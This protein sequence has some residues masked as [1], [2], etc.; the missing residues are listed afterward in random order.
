MVNINTVNSDLQAGIL[1]LQL[2]EQI[3]AGGETLWGKLK[4]VLADHGIAA[5]N[6]E[7]DFIILDAAKRK[8]QAELDAAGGSAAALGGPVL[9]S[10]GE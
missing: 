9:G 8:A 1:W 6:S 5:D 4:T 7:L 2:G 3:I 10:T